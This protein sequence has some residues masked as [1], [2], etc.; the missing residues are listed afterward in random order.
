MILYLKSTKISDIIFV[1]YK[2]RTQL[3]VEV[4]QVSFGD[5]LGL[6]TRARPASIRCTSWSFGTLA[7]RGHEDKG[8]VPLPREPIFSDSPTTMVFCLV[9]AYPVGGF[10]RI[11]MRIGEQ[12]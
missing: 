7:L 11:I 2:T 10:C 12:D 3:I 4:S 8:N 9:Q 6:V 5:W 1:N